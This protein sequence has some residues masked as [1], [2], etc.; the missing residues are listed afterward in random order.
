MGNARS[1]RRPSLERLL[2]E[3]GM[4]ARMNR[5]LAIRQQ[6]LAA[7]ARE[8]AEYTIRTVEDALAE[9]RRQGIRPVAT[10]AVAMPEAA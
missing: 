1:G 6:K 5:E 2:R 8:T 3:L 7:D 9:H 4:S 10:P